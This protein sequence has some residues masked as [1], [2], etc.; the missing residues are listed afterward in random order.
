MKK[1]LIYMCLSA[2]LLFLS[3]C[4]DELNTQP[5]NKVSGSQIFSDVNSAQAAINGIYRMLYLIG[6]SEGYPY[7]NCGQTAIQLL[8]DLM[9]EDHLMNEQGGGWFFPDYRL[10]VHGEFSN[11]SGRSYAVWNFYY[12]LI[13]NLNYIIASENTMEGDPKA[14]KS[15]V[16]QAYAMRAH[17]Y[18]YLIQL[19]Q[20]TYKGHE[21]APG[22]PLYLEPTVSSSVGKPRGTVQGVYDQINADLENATTLLQGLPQEHI[23]HVDYYVAQGIQARVALVQHDYVKAAKAAKEALAKSNLT[24]LSVSDLGG[25]NDADV[26]D[27]MWGVKISASQSSQLYGFFAFMDADVPGSWASQGRQCISSGLYNLIP[28]TDSRLAWF[29][30]KLETD[31]A[32]NSKTSYCQLKFKMADYTTRTG[33]YIFMRAEEMVLIKAE[34]ECHQGLYSDA[35]ATIKPLGELRDPGFAERLAK[36]ADA[37]TYNEDTN[38]PLLTLM[39]EILF[40][41]RVELWGEAGRIFDLQRLGLGYKRDYPGSNHSQKVETKNTNAASPL[42]IFPLPQTEIDGNENI[43]EADQNPVVQ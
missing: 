43:T 33:D 9:G 26:K 19:Y 10:N 8:A 6:W 38:A 42:F 31:E 16:G 37:K 41:R 23:S 13:S 28:E 12:T 1:Y 27:V 14:I 7:E 25:N 40:Q 15:L 5:T 30:G 29:R 11:T 17:S 34:A 39:D 18:F 36:R 2:G 3:S 22:V 32:G 21:N 20:Q 24:L 4:T 35:R